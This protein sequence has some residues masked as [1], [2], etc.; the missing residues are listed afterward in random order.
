[1]AGVIIELQISG[2]GINKNNSGMATISFRVTELGFKFKILVE[3]K[4][5]L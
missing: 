3:T 2:G 4:R 5:G 1:M